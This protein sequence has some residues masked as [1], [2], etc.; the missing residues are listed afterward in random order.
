MVR[1]MISRLSAFCQMNY[2]G[3][4]VYQVRGPVA[5]PADDLDALVNLS[6]TH[7]NPILVK[8]DGKTIGVVTNKNLL[9]G[10]QGRWD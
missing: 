4:Q 5:L 3:H 6:I 9:R 2:D 1:Y 7:E 10:I 8:E